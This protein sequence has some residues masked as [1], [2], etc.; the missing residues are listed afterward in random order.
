MV[1]LRRAREHLC[2]NAEG[3]HSNLSRIAASVLMLSDFPPRV[4]SLIENP[5]KPVTMP[6][7][8]GKYWIEPVNCDELVEPTVM[9]SVQGVSSGHNEVF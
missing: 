7:A 3:K 8:R 5:Q 9:L 1:P 2:D 4:T 6:V